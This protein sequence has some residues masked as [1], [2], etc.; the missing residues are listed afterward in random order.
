MNVVRVLSTPFEVRA[1]PDKVNR[2]DS[3]SLDFRA[4]QPCQY[5]SNCSGRGDRN[6]R[7]RGPLRGAPTYWLRL[8]IESVWQDLQRDLLRLSADSR[9]EIAEKSE[10]AVQLYQPELVV[11]AILRLVS[12]PRNNH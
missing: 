7:F 6:C 12:Q 2:L 10:H 4:P 8:L 3:N 9:Q 1:E 5:R 11:D